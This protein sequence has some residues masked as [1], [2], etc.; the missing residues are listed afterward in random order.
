MDGLC[1][2]VMGLLLQEEHLKLKGS[3]SSKFQ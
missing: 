2:E 3:V 1:T